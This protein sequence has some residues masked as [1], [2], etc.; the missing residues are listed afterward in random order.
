MNNVGVKLFSSNFIKQAL[1]PNKRRSEKVWK[2]SQTIVE[3]S[4]SA[5]RLYEWDK[6][7]INLNVSLSDDHSSDNNNIF[8]TQVCNITRNNTCY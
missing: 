3:A 6:D 8:Q 5:E 2:F 7:S 1:R 4:K